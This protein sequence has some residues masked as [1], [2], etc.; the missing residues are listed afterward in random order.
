MFISNN[1]PSFHLWLKENLLKHPESQNIM[2]LIAGLPIYYEHNILTHEKLDYAM[3]LNA[4][5][6]PFFPEQDIIERFP[7]LNLKYAS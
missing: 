6:T 7:G 5:I 2:K 3:F 1:R 4:T